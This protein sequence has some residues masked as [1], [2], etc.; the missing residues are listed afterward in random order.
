MLKADMEAVR[1]KVK[2]LQISLGQVLLNAKT[3]F[4]FAMFSLATINF[5]R[6]ARILASNQKPPNPQGLEAF[7][8]LVLVLI[9]IF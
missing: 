7:M 1:F 8:F 6:S 2:K 3:N 5:L 9:L 4:I